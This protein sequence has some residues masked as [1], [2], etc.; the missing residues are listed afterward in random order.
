MR[1]SERYLQLQSQKVRTSGFFFLFFHSI[2]YPKYKLPSGGE[3]KASQLGAA[4]G[5][6]LEKV[7][8]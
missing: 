5:Y 7:N 1:S 6:K 2:K 4:T 3:E 8:V